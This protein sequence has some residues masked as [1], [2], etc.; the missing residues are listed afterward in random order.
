MPKNYIDWKSYFEFLNSWLLVLKRFDSDLGEF[1][2][3]KLS[4]VRF[5]IFPIATGLT[6]FY[7]E[8]SRFFCLDGF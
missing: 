2:V 4:M 5:R 1:G 6:G 7:K 8:G 3:E